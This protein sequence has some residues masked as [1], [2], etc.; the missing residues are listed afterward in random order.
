MVYPPESS[1]TPLFFGVYNTSAHI[2]LE[3]WDF[4]GSGVPVPKFCPTFP[5]NTIRFSETHLKANNQK[6]ANPPA[7]SSPRH[8]VYI[9]QNLCA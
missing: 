9:V 2:H 3:L 1:T 5:Q 6:P 4:E 8:K 7:L